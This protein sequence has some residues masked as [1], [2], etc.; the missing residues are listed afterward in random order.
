[1][2][3]LMNAGNHT[4]AS[5]SSESRRYLAIEKTFHLFKKASI[6]CLFNAFPRN[7][8]YFKS[9]LTSSYEDILSYPIPGRKSRGAHAPVEQRRTVLQLHLLNSVQFCLYKICRHGS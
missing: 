5:E 1:M 2:D 3:K 9:W 6:M 4:L 7:D 8:R